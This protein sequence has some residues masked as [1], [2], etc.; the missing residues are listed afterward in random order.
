M[1][2]RTG[3]IDENGAMTNDFLVGEFDDE[4]IDSV[5]ESGSDEGLESDENGGGLV[6]GKIGKFRV[7]DESMRDY[8]P[9]LDEK[10]GI[11]ERRCP[12]KGKG[13]D[14]LVP[15]PKGYKLRI[16]WPKSRN[17]VFN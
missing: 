13:L 11:L 9:C 2:E 15:W 3:I 6:K 1:V 17:E 8:I 12:P 4:V 7:C 14:C 16:P 10:G 5:V